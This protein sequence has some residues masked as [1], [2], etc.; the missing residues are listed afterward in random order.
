MPTA[1]SLHVH[2]DA[3]AADA[4]GS[5]TVALGVQILDASNNPVTS[6]QFG[7]TSL[8]FTQ[9]LNAGYYTIVVR[10]GA[11]PP[12]ENFQMAV[13]ATYFQGGVDVG[14]FAS[15]NSVG[16]GAFYLTAAQQVNIQIYGQ[17]SY[18]ANGAGGLRLTLYDAN[19][20][21]IATVP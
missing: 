12:N 5:S 1:Q 21:V 9:P 10:G 13:G 18:G 8:D 3:Q 11:S 7:G 16:F 15:P 14:G 4:S 6:E 19:R 20:N 2:I 17:P